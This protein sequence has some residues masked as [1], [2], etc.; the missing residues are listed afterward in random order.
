[1]KLHHSASNSRKFPQKANVH[2]YQQSASTTLDIHPT[3]SIKHSSSKTSIP[4]QA[5]TFHIN[6]QQFSLKTNTY[7]LTSSFTFQHHHSLSNN[8]FLKHHLLLSHTSL[9]DQHPE[10]TISILHQIAF[11]IKKHST[12]QHQHLTS[13]PVF[14]IKLQHSASNTN[15]HC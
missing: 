6:H 10:T 5:L 15:V 1:M 11:S 9:K 12:I 14:T 4:Y 8:R 13:T 2:K 7:H 3:F